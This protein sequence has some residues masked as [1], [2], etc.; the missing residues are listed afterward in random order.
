MGGY[1]VWYLLYLVPE[2]VRNLKHYLSS[3]EI[4]FGSGTKHTI[5]ILIVDLMRNL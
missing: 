3:D 2:W 4:V 5:V 1:H